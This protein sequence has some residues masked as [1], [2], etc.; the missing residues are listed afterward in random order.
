M[1]LNIKK[2]NL[3][4]FIVLNITYCTKDLSNVTYTSL[5]VFEFII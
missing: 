2:I 3:V 5:P 4:L 1:K